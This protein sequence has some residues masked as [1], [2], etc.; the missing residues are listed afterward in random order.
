[1]W[2]IC[3][4]R[5]WRLIS[6]VSDGQAEVVD[7]CFENHIAEFDE[8]RPISTTMRARAWFRES[9]DIPET[10]RFTTSIEPPHREINRSMTIH[11]IR[12]SLVSKYLLEFRGIA[13]RGVN[14][15]VFKN[16]VKTRKRATQLLRVAPIAPIRQGA[17]I[18]RQFHHP[19][20]A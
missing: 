13:T 7:S 6:R 18:F 8:P 1:M 4:Y 14:F 5:T 2:G 17:T 10:C 11:Q 15:S 20:H 3:S 12:L 9:R 19:Q 16:Q